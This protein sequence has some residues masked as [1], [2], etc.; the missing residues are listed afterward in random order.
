[1]DNAK[2]VFKPLPTNNEEIAREGF[3]K[4]WKEFFSKTGKFKAV[5]LGL[6]SLAMVAAAVMLFIA[7]FKNNGFIFNSPHQYEET[8]QRVLTGLVAAA[9]PLVTAMF[10]WVHIVASD[11]RG[12]FLRT[13]FIWLGVT[14]VLFAVVCDWTK[15]MHLLL[16]D[17][18]TLIAAILICFVIQLIFFIISKLPP[19]YNR[20][21]RAVLAAEK[22]KDI[23]N[24]ELNKVNE[25]KEK[26]EW[27]AW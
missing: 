25:V 17:L 19:A 6:Y 15:S 20:K 11:E 26:E 18:G 14:G 21:Q 2:F 16:I 27:E 24:A 3:K 8:I 23:D 10:S 9:F 12:T 4:H 13:M 7:A 22:Q 1:M 5:F